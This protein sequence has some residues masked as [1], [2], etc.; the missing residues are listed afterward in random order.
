MT[1]NKDYLEKLNG[2]QRDAVVYC[3]GPELVIAG[4]GSGKTRVLTYKIVHLLRQ[5][6]K[7][8][9][10]LALTFTNKAA[11]EMRERIESLVGQQTASKL[12]MGTFHSIFARI[13]RNNAEYLGFKSSFTIYD[14]SD[15]KSLIKSIVKEKGLDDKTYK[16]ATVLAEISRA[17]NHLISPEMYEADPEIAQMNKYTNKPYMPE[18]YRAYRARCMA[19]NAMDFDDL[20]YYTNKLL[21][22]FPEIK[23]H[24]QEYYQYILVDEYQDTNYAQHRIVS[25]LAERHH[26]L[27]VVGDDAQSIYSFRG[28]N[29]RNILELKKQYPDLHLFR[30]EQNYRS[31]R[32]IVNAAN[33]LIAKNSEQIPKNVFSENETGERIQVAECYSDLDEAYMIINKVRELHR[34]KTDCYS[35]FAILFRTNAQSRPLEEQL[36]K[37][38]IPYI[39][40]KG[41]SFYQRKEIKDSVA[42]FRMAVNPSDDEALKRVIN[43]PARGIGEVTIGKIQAAAVASNTSMWDV[44]QNPLQFGLK[45]NSGTMNKINQFS[46]IISEFIELENSENNNAFDIASLIIRKSGI[47]LSLLSDS[48]PENISRRENIESLLN[49]VK[50]FV[51]LREEE[52]ENPDLSLTSYLQ[53]IAL[54]SDQDESDENGDAV[55]LMTVHSAKGLEFNNVLI[56]GVEDDLFPSSMSKNNIRE[57]EEERR[58]LYVAITRAKSF[59]LISY[60]KNRFRNGAPQLMR[61]SPFLS[62]IDY[63]Y[64]NIVSGSGF[65]KKEI[66]TST[67]SRHSFSSSRENKP[68]PKRVTFS[69][70][71]KPKAVTNEQ[72]SEYTVHSLKELSEGLQIEHSRFGN[73]VI[74]KIDTSTADTKITVQF[75]NAES[76]VLL[77]KFA[78]FKIL[79]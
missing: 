24:L 31:T 15:S 14:T 75:S 65:E 41:Q 23:S 8:H 53:Q 18:L 1:V 66:P 10:I 30:L 58:L 9:R 21:S 33:S 48:T 45:L 50:E 46:S 26:K 62:D 28:A 4:A 32:M 17:K 16:P 71:I 68:A 35:D 69:E 79:N 38:N 64:L 39:I 13:L 20:L 2:P 74:S 7:A 63:K 67:G 42:Y 40:F 51:D 37:Y 78:R 22:D 52:D 3:D 19:A 25:L 36:R 57:I 47:Y 5:G 49:G 12:V 44:I 70:I 6:Y 56:V 55:K 72:S 43:Y 60:A 61:P 11:D 73:G 27:C 77:I 54:A 59:C 29:I 76:K 34:L